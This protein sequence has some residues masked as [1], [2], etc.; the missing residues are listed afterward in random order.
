MASDFVASLKPFP[1][2]DIVIGGK[3]YRIPALPAAD[4]LE[5]LLPEQI[6][7][8]SI[9]P[10]F[11]E[12][13]AEEDVVD[14]MIDGEYTRDDLEQLVWELVSIASGRDW[15]TV[16]YLLGNAKHDQNVGIVKGKLASNGVDAS[17]ISLAAWLDAVY[18]IFAEHMNAED[19]QKFNLSLLRP[20]PGIKQVIDREVQRRNFAALMASE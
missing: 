20:P 3:A 6:S 17:K 2:E 5:I 10:G 7:L 12:P 18:V 11:L 13:E 19:R 15:W 4:W 8:W 9:V 16:L 1:I 14:L